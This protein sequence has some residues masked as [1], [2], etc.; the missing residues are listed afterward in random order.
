[1]LFKSGC[2]VIT[3]KGGIKTRKERRELISLVKSR[4]ASTL[5]LSGIFSFTSGNNLFCTWQDL[6]LNGLC[7]SVPGMSIGPETLAYTARI[8]DSSKAKAGQQK[9]G[10]PKKQVWQ[11][12]EKI[13]YMVDCL[14]FSIKEAER[15]YKKEQLNGNYRPASLRTFER[16]LHLARVEYCHKSGNAAQYS[17]QERGQW[18]QRQ[19]T[20]KNIMSGRQNWT[21]K[22]FAST[23]TLFSG[24]FSKEGRG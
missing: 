9:P 19:N 8:I 5:M 23:N 7:L 10:R 20:D 4:K 1:M 22:V 24:V 11:D 13:R 6:T 21:K 14:G 18:M 2:S 12:R 3:Q 17:Y 15:E 16:V